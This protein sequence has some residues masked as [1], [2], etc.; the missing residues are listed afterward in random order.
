MSI[1]PTP[2]VSV[3]ASSNKGIATS[4]KGITASSKLLLVSSLLLVVMPFV[5]NSVLI[6]ML[7]LFFPL[8][9]IGQYWSSRNYFIAFGSNFTQPGEHFSEVPLPGPLHFCRQRLQNEAG[10]E[11]AL[12]VFEWFTAAERLFSQRCI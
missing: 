8:G 6:L 11:R 4:S 3:L 2:L 12:R 9:T 1:S 7:F 10:S 5:P